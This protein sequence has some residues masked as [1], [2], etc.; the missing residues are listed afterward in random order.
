[1]L[2]Q[3]HIHGAGMLIKPLRQ[4]RPEV[5]GELRLTGFGTAQHFAHGF[6]HHL[7]FTQMA[8]DGREVAG[9]HLLVFK[10]KVFVAMGGETGQQRDHV[11]VARSTDRVKRIDELDVVIVNLR[12]AGGEVG[13]EG[14]HVDA[15]KSRWDNSM[16]RIV[17]WFG[18]DHASEVMMHAFHR[19]FYGVLL[20]AT[21]MVS[22][23]QGQ[24]ARDSALIDAA[25]RGDHAA[26]QRLLKEG[27]SVTTRDA[28]GRTALLAAVQAN[29]IEA[30]R[31]LIAA[32]ANVNTQDNMQD[33][34]YLL[35]GARGRV[36]ILRMTLA[37][38]ADL[39][40]TNRYGGTALTPACHYGHVET[41]RELLKTSV[42]IDHVNNLGWTC[43]LEAVILGDGGAAHLD[44]VRLVVAAGA[45]VNLA[46]KQGVTPLAHARQRGQQEI[47]AA[48]VKAGAK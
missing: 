28:S 10:T 36:E 40:S 29:R 19:M 23:A 12:I 24:T 8:A 33:S 26:V 31:L 9:L 42:A 14:E 6:L 16:T 21:L 44:I 48:L 47:A 13:G 22:T 27:A 15:M 17:Y 34:P 11:G 30:A 1:M 25:A 20:C 41:V 2:R 5:F 7:V 37:A 32:G 38:G 18:F 4:R 46:D 45:N 35:A 43:L 3:H 39:K